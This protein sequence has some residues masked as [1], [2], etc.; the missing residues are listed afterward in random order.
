MPRQRR[1]LYHARDSALARLRTAKLPLRFAARTETQWRQWRTRLRRAIRNELRPMPDPVPLRPQV[2]ERTDKGTYIREK[3]VFDSEA[4]GSVPAYVLVPKG[5]KRG[6]KRPAILCAHGHGIG[7]DA[8]VGLEVDGEPIYDYQKQMAVQFTERG[9]VT[10]SPDWRNFG[11]RADTAEW[12]RGSRD[13][14]NVASLAERYFG[15]HMLALEIC[16]AQRTLDYL[17]SR[18]EV[19]PRRIGCIG[20]SFGGTMTTYLSALDQRVKV[21]VISGYLSSLKNAL[22]RANFCGSQMMP[23]LLKHCEI[24]DVAGLIA[25][26]PLLAE[27]GEE[28]TCFEVKDAMAAYRRVRQVY[29][30]AGALD[31]IAVDRFPGP[32]E[33]SGLKAFDWFDKWL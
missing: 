10:I 22:G 12:V 30:V 19:D 17:Q 4:F 18:R 3:V 25:P 15:Y 8:L 11:E 21:A 20:V 6:E 9:Y 5:L 26:R 33:F 13:K 29:E 14:C 31:R 7:K 1:R 27:I 32:H 24:S 23:G 16:D 28:D 2:L